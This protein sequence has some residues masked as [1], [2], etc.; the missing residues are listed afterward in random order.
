MGMLQLRGRLLD[1]LEVGVDGDN[2]IRGNVHRDLERHKPI[3][4]NADVMLTAHQRNGTLPRKCSALSIIDDNSTIDV[5][6]D[7]DATDLGSEVV[8]SRCDCNNLLRA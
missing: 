8:Y 7:P 3:S 2:H 1:P 6:R 5:G 4:D